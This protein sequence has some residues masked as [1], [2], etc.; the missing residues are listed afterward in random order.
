MDAFYA[1]VEQRDHPELQGKP[2]IVGGEPG[3]RSVVSTCS[4]EA[5]KYGIRSAMPVDTAVKLCPEAVI[6]PPRFRV[7]QNISGQINEIFRLFTPLVEPLSLDEAFLD[8]T[9]SLRLFGSALG[10]AGQIKKKIKA[11]TSLVASAA[12]A[13]N[14]FLAKLATSIYKPDGLIEINTQWV[15]EILPGLSIKMLWGVGD[16]TAGL[17]ETLGFKTIGDIQKTSE[18]Y[19]ARYIGEKSARHL[20]SIAC[21]EDSRSVEI[22][23][24]S[25]STG[26]SVTFDH[27]SSNCIFLE[28]EIKKLAGSVCRTLRAGGRFAGQVSIRI[29]FADFSEITRQEKLVPRSS[30]TRNITEKALLLFRRSW[31]GKKIRL[32]GVTLAS[33]YSEKNSQLDFFQVNTEK[34]E[35]ADKTADELER[36]FG[37][38]MRL[39]CRKI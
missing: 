3:T 13:P 4:Y 16:K 22:P 2:V 26:S 23:G 7:Y 15:K 32:L 12:S 34:L 36:R 37:I 6:M 1:A 30:A 25:K 24:R 10:I 31:N 14:K 28:N 29:R 27:D 11:E 35:N 9:G 38:P 21:A 5:R 8:V 33:L 17:L 18:D 20:K 19:L 39:D